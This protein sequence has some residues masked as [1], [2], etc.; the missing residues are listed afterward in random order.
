MIWIFVLLLMMAIKAPGWLF[1]VWILI[2]GGKLI[3]PYLLE[4]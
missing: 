3:L 1:W 4:A 2:I